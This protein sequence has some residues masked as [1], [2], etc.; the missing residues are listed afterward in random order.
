MK[1]F[2]ESGLKRGVVL[3]QGFIYTE[4]ERKVSEKVVFKEE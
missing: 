4:T 3:D 1:G 2:R